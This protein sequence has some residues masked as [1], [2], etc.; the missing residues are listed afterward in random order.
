[1]KSPAQ[2]QTTDVKPPESDLRPTSERKRQ[3]EGQGNEKLIT[4]ISE[5]PFEHLFTLH[6]AGVYTDVGGYSVHFTVTEYYAVSGPQILA[7]LR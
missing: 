1:M 2:R 3:E 4:L 6:D 5:S 7:E